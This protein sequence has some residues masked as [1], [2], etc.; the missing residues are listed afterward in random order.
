MKGKI[1]TEEARQKMSLAKKGKPSPKKGVTMSEEAK[2]NVR[3]QRVYDIMCVETKEIFNSAGDIIRTKI[4]DGDASSVI[5]S[6]HSGETYRGFHWK[7][8][9]K[10]YSPEGMKEFGY[11]LDSP[12]YDAVKKLFDK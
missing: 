12:I 11:G 9:P 7:Y 3:N 5:K 6:I 2:K 8:V 4:N 1:H 10:G